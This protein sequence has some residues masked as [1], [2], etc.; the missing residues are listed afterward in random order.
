MSPL[1][2]RELAALGPGVLVNELDSAD[3]EIGEG[4]NSSTYV[5]G[6]IHAAHWLADRDAALR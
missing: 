3:W 4:D 6:L 2:D 1:S 5:A